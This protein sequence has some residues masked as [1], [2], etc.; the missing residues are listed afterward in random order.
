MNEKLKKKKK[1]ISSFY[2]ASKPLMEWLEKNRC[3]HDIAIVD[4]M[5]AQ[6]MNGEIGVASPLALR[7]GLDTIDCKSNK[8]KISE[9]KYE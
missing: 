9:E 1:K 5:G 6:L 8:L 4:S 3:P 7:Y 2:E